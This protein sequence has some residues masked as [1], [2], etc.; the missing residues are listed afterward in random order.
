M[1]SKSGSRSPATLS[2]CSL[3]RRRSASCVVIS[4]VLAHS[5]FSTQLLLSFFSYLFSTALQATRWARSSSTVLLLCGVEG[6][7]VDLLSVLGQI[8]LD[9]VRKLCDLL[10]GRLSSSLGSLGRGAGL[11]EEFLVGVA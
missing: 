10:V 5:F 7:L 11:S 4:T 3:W 6:L 2:G 8:V 9:V 1:C